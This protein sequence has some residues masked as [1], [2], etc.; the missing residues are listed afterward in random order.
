MTHAWH[1]ASLQEVIAAPNQARC[2]LVMVE[3]LT[4]NHSLS[5]V[6]TQS[7]GQRSEKHQVGE[8]GVCC[9]NISSEK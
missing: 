8:T 4:Q 2:D 9:R 1:T 5:S 3:N 6:L 7:E